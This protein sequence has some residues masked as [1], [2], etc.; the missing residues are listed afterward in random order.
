MHTLTALCV[1]AAAIGVFKCPTTGVRLGDQLSSNPLWH[2]LGQRGR[3][4]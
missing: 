4:E 2:R 1:I 3:G